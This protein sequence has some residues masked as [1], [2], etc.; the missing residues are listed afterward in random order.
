M[1][2]FELLNPNAQQQLQNLDQDP[3][4]GPNP[5]DDAQGKFDANKVDSHLQ[6]IAQGIGDENAQPEIP[7]GAEGEPPELDNQNPQ[8]IDDALIAATK[9]LPYATNWPHKDKDKT[10]PM[11]ILGMQLADLSNLKNMVRYK[12]QI[13]T[14]KNSVGNNENKDMEYYGDL[15]KFVNTVT[16]FKRSN[17]KTQLAQ[18]NPT[19]AY[20]TTRGSK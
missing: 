14:M 9:N 1:K 17:T 20:Q 13:L 6:D 3:N 2:I 15:L 12:I 16:A 10:S 5:E 8:P 4:Q 11:N 7:Q 19:P 18:T